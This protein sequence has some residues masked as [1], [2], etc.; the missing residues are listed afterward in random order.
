MIS[1][2]KERKKKYKTEEERREANKRNKR[3]WY[4]RNRDKEREFKEEQDKYLLME[5]E[6]LILDN[7]IHLYPHQH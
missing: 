7:K 4:Y 2:K 3:E 5:Y 1:Q 6:E